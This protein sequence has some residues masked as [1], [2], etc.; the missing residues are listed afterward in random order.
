MVQWMDSM[1]EIHLLGGYNEDEARTRKVGTGKD[2]T[3]QATTTKRFRVAEKLVG[4]RSTGNEL[5]SVA[6]AA[7]LS[8]DK[9]KIVRPLALSLFEETPDV[10]WGPESIG[11][12]HRLC[13]NS[14]S[15]YTNHIFKLFEQKQCDVNEKI[16]EIAAYVI[17]V[18][19]D[20]D[21]SDIND[22]I[23]ET[24]DELL[25]KL[26]KYIETEVQNMASEYHSRF[27]SDDP[28]MWS[29][30]IRIHNW[31]NCFPVLKKNKRTAQKAIK[32]EAFIKDANNG[33]VGVFSA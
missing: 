31:A 21:Q 18:D 12:L 32:I 6:Y 1:S 30:L 24:K 13:F 10:Y 2:A 3:Y 25:V 5:A 15:Q 16:T 8:L 14:S 9:M 28:I 11:G 23:T 29:D 4:L 27:E 26:I 17:E 20:T 22:M 19:N 7:L 33:T